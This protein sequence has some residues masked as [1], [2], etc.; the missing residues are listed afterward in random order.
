M[1]A[2][3]EFGEAMEKDDHS[4]VFRSGSNRVQAYCA[5]LEREV[6]HEGFAPS[7]QFSC[8]RELAH[9][10]NER[11]QLERQGNLRDQKPGAPEVAGRISGALTPN[12]RRAKYV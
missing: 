10:K 5:I 12:R 3:P 8:D 11:Y 9:A 2:V 4:A 7:M 1:P 6:F